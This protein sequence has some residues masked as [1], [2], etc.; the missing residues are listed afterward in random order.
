[1]PHAWPHRPDLRHLR[2]RCVPATKAARFPSPTLPVRTSDRAGPWYRPIAASTDPVRAHRRSASGANHD[3][4]VA[5]RSFVRSR[6]VSDRKAHA[7]REVIE[8]DETLPM[9]APVRSS[10]PS[11]PASGDRRIGRGIR[12]IRRRRGW[13]QADL[14]Q[15]AGVSQDTISRI[16]R[17]GL[18]LL[19]VDTVRRVADALD[20]HV[21]IDLRWQGA[22]L[23]RLLDERHAEL[24]AATA[25]ALERLG[26]H[27]TAELSYS[28]FGER[29]SI[30]LVGW[31]ADVR[32]LLVVE[33]K[34]EL[35]SIELTLRKLDEKERLAGHVVAERFGWRAATVSR[36]LVLP[37][38]S[39]PRRQVERHAGLL[40]RSLPMR[41]VALRAALRVPRMKIDGLL[42]VSTGDGPAHQSRTGRRSRGARLV[43]QDAR[44]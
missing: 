7:Y 11:S 20:A 4:A 43:G 16:E 41:G 37:D 22:A 36:L 2:S 12:A 19:Q 33:V 30:D 28:R 29:G 6:C 1:M 9:T 34:T 8:A 27:V 21:A 40:S 14:A 26:W 23:D 15:A 10:R 32:A 38:T 24:V 31:R 25:S 3:R 42:F 44:H 39:T 18:W 17:G 13:R 35:G 5:K